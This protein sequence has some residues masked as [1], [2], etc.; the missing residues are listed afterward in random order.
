MKRDIETELK[1]WKTSPNRMPLIIRGARQVGKSF[2]IEKFGNEFFTNIMTINFEFEPAIASLFE[3]PNPEEIVAQLEIKKKTKITPGETLLF[4]DE[5][6]YC[7]KA[8]IALRY[9]KEKMPNLH[10]IAAGSLLEFTLQDH[11]FSFPV[12]RVEFLYLRP[13]SFNEF[14]YNKG[15]LQLLDAFEQ[16]S[17]DNPLPESIH[18]HALELFK[19]YILIGGMPAVTD[20]FL[21][22]NSYL[23]CQRLQEILTQT[24][25]ND[26]GKYATKTQ[27]KHL[28]KCFER[29][30]HLIGQHFKFV[31]VDRESRSRDIKIALEQLCWAGLINRIYA[32]S[33]SGIPLMAQMNENKFKLLYLDIGLLQGIHQYDNELILNQ[34]ILQINA[35]EL[36]EQ[37]VGQELLAY[38]KS[39]ENKQLFYWNREAKS[40]LAEVD[41]VITINS[42]IV[43]I[44]V[45][46]GTTGRLKSLREFMKEKK[47]T[48]G[49]RVS[50]NPLSLCDNILSVP[51]YL[52][53]QLPR[54]YKDKGTLLHKLT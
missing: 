37:F 28:Q 16:V 43:P 30:P 26:F 50:Q 8:I 6:Q 34:D 19:K 20:L 22:H 14:L 35:G 44:E 42:E 33:A 7:P 11:N 54:L 12:G 1:K 39:Y 29:A 3:T 45:K 24:Y 10:V 4:L 41:F 46:A 32:T 17:L 36:A 2:T 53:K 49:I 13:L 18:N 5:I 15:E 40:S 25:R 9:F 38:G 23:E 21:K 27:Y 47:S 31:S 52:L 48:L 51:F